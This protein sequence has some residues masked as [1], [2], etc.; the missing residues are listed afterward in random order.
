M[1]TDEELFPVSATDAIYSD[2]YWHRVIGARVVGFVIVIRA[3]Q[4]SKFEK[5]PNEVGLCFRLDNGETF[6]AAHQLCRAPDDF[7]LI[8]YSEIDP[9]LK[10]ELREVPLEALLA[11]ARQRQRGLSGSPV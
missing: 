11:A 7:V 5:L 9:A 4:S 1:A 10:S 6:V 2:P 8:P 3:P